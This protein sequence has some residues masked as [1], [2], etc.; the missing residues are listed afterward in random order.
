MLNTLDSRTG[1][2]VNVLVF[3]DYNESDYI[4]K[5]ENRLAIVNAILELFLDFGERK[6]RVGIVEENTPIA[7]VHTPDSTVCQGVATAKMSTTTLVRR[8]NNTRLP[9]MNTCEQSG[10]GGGSSRS[11]STGTG[12]TFFS[13]PGGSVPR[14]TNCFSSPGGRRSFL[15]SPGGRLFA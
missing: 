1:S 2:T 8:F 7:V 11:T 12:S 5:A 3:F 14:T 9:P 13:N 15:A 6:S 4:E 10:G